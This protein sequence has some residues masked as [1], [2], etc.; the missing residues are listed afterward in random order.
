MVVLLGGESD[1]KRALIQNGC[2]ISRTVA[3][4][5]ERRGSSVPDSPSHTTVITG[6]GGDRHSFT[7][8]SHRGGMATIERPREASQSVNPLLTTA[9]PTPFPRELLQS[10][11]TQRKGIVRPATAPAISVTTNLTSTAEQPVQDVQ[12]E[13]TREDMVSCRVVILFNFPGTYVR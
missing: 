2:R 4:A 5:R 13:P 1:N 9:I 11:H 7:L 12:H 3:E 8:I 6:R 10:A